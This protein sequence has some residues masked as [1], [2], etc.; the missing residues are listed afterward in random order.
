MMASD[1]DVFRA[2]H[3]ILDLDILRPVRRVCSSFD[4]NYMWTNMFPPDI[5]SAGGIFKR[6]TDP[7]A[8]LARF[9][10]T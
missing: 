5:T 6:I 8:R 10:Q 4:G 1:E 9:A 7:L 2:K 3:Q